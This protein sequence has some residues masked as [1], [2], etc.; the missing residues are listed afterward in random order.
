[1]IVIVGSMILKESIISDFHLVFYISSLPESNTGFIEY[2][3]LC[4]KE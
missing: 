1:M 4:R 2:M 3:S